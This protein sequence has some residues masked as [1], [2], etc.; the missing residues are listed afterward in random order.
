MD[1]E[2]QAL[3]ENDTWD[4]IKATPETSLIG[5]RW[6]YSVK[7]KSDGSLDRYKAGLSN[8]GQFIRWM[9]RML[10]SMG[11]MSLYGL[12]QAPRAFE[13]FRRKQGVTILFLYVDDILITGDDIERISRLQ[14][15]L[16][17]SFKMKDLGPL[18]YFLGLEV[19][20]NSR[21]YFVNQQK[22]AAD[23]V[24]LANLS[25]SK[26]V[27]TPLELNLKLN[28]DDGSPLED[29]TLYRQLVGSLIYLTMTQLD[30]SYA[31]QIVSQF[32]SSPRQPHLSTFHQIIR[33][34]RGTLSHGIFFSSSSPIHLMAYADAD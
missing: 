32:V 16:S 15:L 25:D 20:R 17:K 7:L 10:F 31:V 34:V 30:I 1:F 27:G 5:S 14:Q 2:I 3:L 22:Y 4:L 6:V 12:K 26:I 19:S 13:K 9:S 18:T 23:L 11:K 24:K 29:P 33:Y 21:G 28:K 8:N